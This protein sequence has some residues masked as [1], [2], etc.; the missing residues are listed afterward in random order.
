MASP[1]RSSIGR[2]VAYSLAMLTIVFGTAEILA[3]FLGREVLEQA[4]SPPP[5]TDDDAPNLLGNPFL[6]YE[7]APGERFESGITIQ[8]N[9]MGLRGP[10]WNPDKPP[11]I[12]RVMALG[13]SSVYGFG[14]EDDEVFTARLD[15]ALGEGVQ[16]INSAVP[17]YS[18][19]Q[20][21]NLLQIRSLSLQPDLMLIGCIW[22]DN[23]FD[24]FVDRDLLA[25]Y[26][27][28]RNRHARAVQE[29]LGGSALYTIL[30]YKLRVLR[31]FPEERRVGWMVGRGEK[32]G[33]RR[34][35]IV[36]YA[37]NLETIV[38]L[39]HDAGA[40][41][42][43]MVLPNREDLV[44][45]YE[46]GAAWDPYRQ[47]MR[48]TALRHGAPVLELPELFRASGLDADALFLDEMHPTAQGHALWAQLTQQTLEE[49]GWTEGR[50]LQ[51][52]PK[53]GPI[54]DYEDPFVQGEH[55]PPQG[56]APP[57]DPGLVDRRS[58]ATGRIAGTITVPELYQGAPIQLDALAKGSKQPG[59]LGT[60]RVEGSGPF[61]LLLSDPAEVVVFVAYV[62]KNGD[63]PGPGDPRI[64]LFGGGLELPPDGV[65]EGVQ[66]DLGAGAVT[67]TFAGDAASAAPSPPPS[68]GEAT[69]PPPQAPP[70][71]GPIVTDQPGSSKVPR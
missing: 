27:S 40:E 66:L 53:P 29:L 43:F 18:T 4:A 32:I 63:G 5:T 6:L 69:P 16:V 1:P 7:M 30:D 71:D 21:I 20:I 47:V 9:S 2:R 8:I 46:S 67:Q 34:V 56:E 10:E 58:A 51:R 59:V 28:F 25:A 35:P 49:R 48:D 24:S 65:L 26:S 52:D 14:V 19:Y 60:L 11:S 15:D 61:E 55:A 37:R 42:T 44:A 33:E 57:E 38:E 41:V 68:P 31:T 23:N 3:R 54:P 45:R 50:P 39:A 22:S 64:D 17:G 70:S 36:E 13:D 62:D 12:R